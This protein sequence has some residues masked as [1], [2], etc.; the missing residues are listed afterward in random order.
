METYNDHDV[1]WCDTDEVN[2]KIFYV[3]YFKSWYLSTTG[4]P[5]QE[6]WAYSDVIGSTDQCPPKGSWEMGNDFFCKTKQRLKY[7]NPD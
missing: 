1:Y 2:H 7:N 5:G 6:G 4:L 3:S